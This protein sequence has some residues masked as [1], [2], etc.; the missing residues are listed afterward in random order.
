MKRAWSDR[1]VLLSTSY[2]WPN[3]LPISH[4]ASSFIKSKGK[5]HTWTHIGRVRKVTEF[6]VIP[7]S[8]HLRTKRLLLKLQGP[9]SNTQVNW[10]SS[11]NR[12]WNS[13]SPTS[14]ILKSFPSL[15]TDRSSDFAA[16]WLYGLL[17]TNL[18]NSVSEHSSIVFSLW[19]KFSFTTSPSFS[20][21]CIFCSFSMKSESILCFLGVPQ[22]LSPVG[23]KTYL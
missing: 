6:T 22:C 17:V 20:V 10:L 11:L 23:R 15:H 7:L 3:P 18:P 13:P 9:F 16:L 8:H 2:T 21:S 12:N 19:A 4:P 5:P 14:M 1:K